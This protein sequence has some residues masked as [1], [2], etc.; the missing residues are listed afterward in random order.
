MSKAY[1]VDALRTPRARRKGQL[2][3]V[4]P[5]DLLAV[6]LKEIAARH[7][8]AT[9]AIE[10]VIIGCVTQT[11]E[12]AWCLAR[13]A[14]L[15]A[16]FPESVPGTTVNR[17]CA[18][19]L[20]AVMFG[21]MG[22]QS[23]NQEI[24][25]AG[26]VEHMTRVPMFADSGGEESP[27]LVARFPDL[28]PQGLSA[29]KIVEHYRFTREQLDSYS[30]AS[31]LRAAKAV[32]EKFFQKSIVPVTKPD[33]TIFSTDDN[34][35]AESTLEKLLS[36]KPVFKDDGSITAGNASAIVDGAAA[37]LLASEKALQLHNLK[38]RAQVVGFSQIGS[39][40]RL[41]LTGP[42]AAVR[43][44]LAKTGLSIKDID[45]WEINEAFAPIPLL[46]MQELGIS[47]EITNV[48]G[49]GISLGHPLGATGAMLIGM[50][51]DE[52]ERREKKRACITLCIGLGMACAL[53]IERV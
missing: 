34:F 50:A 28:T 26:G 45:L 20:Q 8:L 53:V 48:N 1:I 2:Q 7:K 24:V 6:P 25:L 35:R 31:H 23:G 4:H 46:V 29:E 39:D 27:G 19:G 10:D 41:M 52:L 42:T 30:L 22:I 16:G 3:T 17:L 51:L 5:V 37:V 49:G 40:P 47:P 43:A 9:A 38:P 11:Q 15:V 44:V 36:L 12:Q 33:G 13:K 18:S 21:S 14:A 32:N